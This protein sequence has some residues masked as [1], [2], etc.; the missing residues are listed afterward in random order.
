M[1]KQ[2]DSHQGH[3]VQTCIHNQPAVM[4][5]AAFLF[6]VFIMCGS[7]ADVLEV[8]NGSVEADRS[9]ILFILI[10]LYK[11]VKIGVLNEDTSEY[12]HKS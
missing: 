4:S 10:D 2:E 11:S 1:V 7:P 9:D 8:K 6:A 12:Y 3:L 5:Q